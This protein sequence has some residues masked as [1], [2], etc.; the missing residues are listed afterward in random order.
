MVLSIIDLN[1]PEKTVEHLKLMQTKKFKNGGSR[2]SCHKI[3]VDIEAIV[4]LDK[5]GC[6]MAKRW[7]ILVIYKGN[8]GSV[9]LLQ[10]NNGTYELV[11]ALV[12]PAYEVPGEIT[13]PCD[14]FGGTLKK[15][16]LPLS[17]S[18][19]PIFLV[20]ELE[21][22]FLFK[23]EPETLRLRK[24]EGLPNVGAN[25]LLIPMDTSEDDKYENALHVVAL[26]AAD[27]D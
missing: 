22:F 14:G 2:K 15:V 8:M 19:T 10:C 6:S 9:R 7:Q 3:D 17:P 11:K 20:D 5:E 21:T 23:I 16:F 25:S 1:M 4:M 24:Y 12:N 13:E 27:E 26:R 18:C